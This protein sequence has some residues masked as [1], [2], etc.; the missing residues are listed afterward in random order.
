MNLQILLW[1]IRG[2]S[3]KEKIKI[4]EAKGG[5]SVFIGNKDPRDDCWD[6]AQPRCG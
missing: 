2:A 5:L 6:S 4:I 3:N 1:N